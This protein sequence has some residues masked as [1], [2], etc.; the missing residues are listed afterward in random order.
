MV[1]GD[2]GTAALRAGSE[3]YEYILLSCVHVGVGRGV[4]A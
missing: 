1:I 4:G 2:D 3:E